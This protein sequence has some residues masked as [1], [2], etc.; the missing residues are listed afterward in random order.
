MTW[1]LFARRLAGLALVFSLAALRWRWRAFNA[2]P[3]SVD[4]L[5]ISLFV[6]TGTAALLNPALLPGFYLLSVLLL[7]Y[8]RLG[9]IRAEH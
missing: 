1:E 8:A 2:L 4:Y 9:K 3:R 5:L 7:A 6:T